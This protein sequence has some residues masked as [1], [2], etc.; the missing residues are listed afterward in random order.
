MFHAPSSEAAPAAS[1]PHAPDA[2]AAAAIFVAAGHLL[3]HLEKG[4]AID[5]PILRSAMELAFGTS[6]ASGAWD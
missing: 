4:R 2:S 1:R 3:P 6:D 5:A